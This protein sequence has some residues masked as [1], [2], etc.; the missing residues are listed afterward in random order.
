MLAFLRRTINLVQLVEHHFSENLVE[1]VL[2]DDP[3]EKVTDLVRMDVHGVLVL[4][5]WHH[6]ELICNLVLDG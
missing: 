3:F 6:G 5:E 2:L 4:A 1:Q